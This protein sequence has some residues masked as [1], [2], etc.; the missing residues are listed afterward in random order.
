M[1]LSLANDG[2]VSPK[3]V[4]GKEFYYWDVPLQQS[5]LNKARS[6]IIKYQNNTIKCNEEG[7]GG[8]F[9]PT[10]SRQLFYGDKMAL[11]HVLG[12]PSIEKIVRF[13]KY[14]I[15][16]MYNSKFGSDINET[17]VVCDLISLIRAKPNQVN[18][19]YSQILT[20]F[21]RNM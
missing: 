16:E 18:I 19:S 10:N 5:F 13:L 2:I 21:L 20:L 4:D 14:R 15:V 7:C 9:Y 17:N 11:K 12:D 3:N 8:D 1:A 6:K